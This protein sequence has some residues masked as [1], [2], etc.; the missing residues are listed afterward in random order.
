MNSL[1]PLKFT[2]VYK[3]KIWGGKKIQTVL[4]KDF[5]PLPNAGEAW[6]LSGVKNSETVV[7]NGYL[8]GNNLSE[9][10][11]I[12]MDDL[13]G[14]AV[15]DKFQNE[16]PILVKFIDA[17]KD[18]SIQ[19]HP[20]DELAKKRYNSLGKTEMWYVIDADD[21]AKLI[22]GL[23]ETTDKKTYVDSVEN[24]SLQK[25][26]NYESV[27]KGDVFYIPSGRIHAINKGIFLAE[28]QQSSDVTYRIYDYNRKDDKGN[29]RELHTDQAVD[30]I[31]YEKHSN[32]RTEY[33]AK[34][35]K[36][37]PLV[38]SKYFI[39]NILDLDTGVGKDYEEL[40]S[41][42]IH[43]CVEGSYVLIV[44]EEKIEMKMGDVVLLPA[45]TGKVSMVP[46]KK[47][48]ILETFMVIDGEVRSEIRQNL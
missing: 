13:V 2:S 45:I 24:N 12:F 8:A 7:E 28:I 16:F 5:S 35:N 30:A 4:G 3:D 22:S 48:K 15:F 17:N 36:T 44:D 43:L 47:T 26:L 9:L 19:V 38:N 42:V 46:N 33:E 37:V 21:D 40:D 14:G 25:L 29:A 18:L 6:V 39:T 23:K 32:Y 20:N 1:Y 27:S 31:D 41:F 34:K 11:E 10:V